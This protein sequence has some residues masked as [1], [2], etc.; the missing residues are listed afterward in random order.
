MDD[1]QSLGLFQRT[2]EGYLECAFI[3][4]VILMRRIPKIEGEVDNFDDHITDSVSVWQRFEHFVGFYRGVKSFAYHNVPMTLSAFHAGTL[5][6]PIDGVEINEPKSRKVLEA[7]CQYETK[8]GSGIYECTTHRDSNKKLSDM[9]TIILNGPSATAGDL[10]MSIELTTGCRQVLCNEVLQCKLLQT[11]KK[12]R[13]SDYAKERDKAVN[14]NSD[15]FLLITSGGTNKFGLSPRCGLVSIAEFQQYFD[16]FA[17]RAYRRFLVPPDINVVSYRELCRVEGLGA[18]LAARILAERE[19][20]R[21]SSVE[22]AVNRLFK[23]HFCKTANV[24]RGL[25]C[26]A[27]AQLE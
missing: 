18:Q 3:F 9:N 6:G 7:V 8:S 14:L 13:E 10:F 11:K 4:L 22:D 27:R 25:Y 20:G 19:R 15:V 5:F 16:P 17:S 24:V 2:R 12:L 26:V 21:F 23:N 1:L